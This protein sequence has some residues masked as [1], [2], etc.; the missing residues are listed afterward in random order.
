MKFIIS[1]GFP[2]FKTFPQLT[3][4][5]FILFLL[6]RYSRWSTV[7][8]RKRDM[9]K[10][11]DTSSFLQTGVG[12]KKSSDHEMFKFFWV[13]END[14][15]SGGDTKYPRT[16]CHNENIRNEIFYDRYFLNLSFFILWWKVDEI[17]FCAFLYVY[18]ISFCNICLWNFMYKLGLVIISFDITCCVLF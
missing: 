6:K 12:Q 18:D 5:F 13:Q 11:S 17:M 4:P 14:L 8:K 15:L 9:K 7:I 16:K 3:L 10:V 1:A 2:Q